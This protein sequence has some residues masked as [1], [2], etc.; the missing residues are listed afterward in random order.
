MY[1]IVYLIWNLVNGKK[2]VGQTT[3]TVKERFREH[4]QKNS[5][6][7]NAIRNYGE[8]N[9]RYGVIKRCASKMEMDKW[10]KYF[11]AMLR[12]KAPIGYNKT[13]GGSGTLG[14][15][16]TPEHC[17]KLA[18]ANKG[19]RLTA[20]TCAKIS[21]SLSGEKHPLFGKHHTADTCAK[22]A[23]AN[24]GKH[25]T[26]ATR[27][28]MAVSHRHNSPFKNLLNELDTHQLTYTVLAKLLE[29]SITSVSMKMQGNAG[30]NI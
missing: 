29:L 20:D 17:A 21:A 14:Y 3:K 5:L 16:P 11:I 15:S 9:F 30:K 7:G 1:G 10:E 19:K 25:H 28:K 24:V 13:T 8:E 12:C 2:Y 4:P 23:A 22:I 6:I 27:S 26:A 18:A